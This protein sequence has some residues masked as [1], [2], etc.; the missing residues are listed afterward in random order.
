MEKYV[1]PEFEVIELDK[2]DAILTSGSG[3]CIIVSSTV[4]WEDANGNKFSNTTNN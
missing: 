2:N 1:K 4:Y 3:S